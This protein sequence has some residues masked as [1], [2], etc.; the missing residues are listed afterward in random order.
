MIG[1]LL[2]KQPNPRWQGRWNS[3]YIPKAKKAK[4]Q[5]LY[6][7]QTRHV[8]RTSQTV[9]LVFTTILLRCCRDHHSTRE[10]GKV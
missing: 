5:L 6:P 8:A 4:E 2:D 9:P 1:V 7:I 3:Y 10:E